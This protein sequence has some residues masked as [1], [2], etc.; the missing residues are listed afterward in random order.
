MKNSKA[1]FDDFVNQ[2]LL[3]EPTEEV[4]SIAFLVFEK[5]YGLSRSQIMADKPVDDHKLEKLKEIIKR[6]NKQEPV[7]YILGEGHFF[8]RKFK[9]TSDVL[10]PRPETEELVQFVIDHAKKSTGNLK[11]IDIGTGSGCI[12]VSLSLALPGA[13]V[14]ATDVSDAALELAVENNNQLGGSVTFIHNDILNQALEVS[15]IDI[16]VSNPPYI[17]DEE[18]NAMKSNVLEFEPHLALFVAGDDPLIFYKAISRQSIK[19]LRKPGMLCTEINEH[20]GK[21][22]ARIFRQAGFKD[23]TIIRDLQGKE[24]IVSGILTS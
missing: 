3:S 24:R 23:V 8:G 14:I 18:K 19:V 1:L 22:V 12:P 16:V 10:I 13:E 20:F 2:L 9:V 4:Q 17:S 6:L 5:L 7:Q 11:I 21:E 15:G